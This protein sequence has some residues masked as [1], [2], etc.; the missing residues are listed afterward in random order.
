M[1]NP[2]IVASRLSRL[3]EYLGY[4]QK[5]RRY[6]Y[7]QFSRDPFIR[8]SAER[9]LQLAIE[10]CL[11]LGNHLI[12]DRGLRKAQDYAEVFGILGE[13]KFIPAAFAKRIAPMAGF[14]N[15]LVHD[16]LRVDPKR[17]YEFLQ[18]RLGDFE[19][20]SRAIA[21]TLD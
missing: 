20:F 2:E 19:R 5:L 1:V 14:R 11:D 9:Y 15:I 18:E 12:S 13:A 6:P 17:V 21:K 16:Y 4:L 10:C 7:R 3:Q 8:G